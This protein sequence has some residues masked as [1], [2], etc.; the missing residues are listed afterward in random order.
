MT[1]LK[2]FKNIADEIMMEIKAGESLKEKTLSQCMKKRNASGRKLLAAAACL[3]L[4][5]GFTQLYL[6]MPQ[7][8]S[9]KER[10]NQEMNI[11]AAPGNNA[12]TVG[13][14]M[15]TVSEAGAVREWTP[16]TI[17][18]AGEAFGKE[19]LKPAAIP[20]GFKIGGIS[21]S[22]K[23]TGSADKIILNYIANDRSFMIIEEKAETAEGG[24][25]NYRTVDINGVTGYI[26]S[27]AGV[28][29][30]K[31]AGNEDIEVSEAEI[32]WF[33]NGVRYAVTGL[34]TEAEA[35]DI[36]LSMK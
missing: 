13:T 29:P 11:M 2:D 19:F 9:A 6:K 30:G 20:E 28:E 7:T 4:V 34:I 27:G 10:N 36:T 35:L 16:G 25:D 24:F 31:T 22:G 8:P 18:E 3:I 12:E 1:E 26:K 21:A 23:V 17:L 32:R 33:E 15:D 14:S 5:F